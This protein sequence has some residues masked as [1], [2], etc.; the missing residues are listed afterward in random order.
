MTTMGAADAGGM[1]FVIREAAAEG[2]AQGGGGET[3]ADR[4]KKRKEKRRK[5]TTRGWKG[6]DKEDETAR[7][8]D[9]PSADGGEDDGAGGGAT[10]RKVKGLVCC[11]SL[12]RKYTYLNLSILVCRAHSQCWPR[13]R[14][15]WRNYNLGHGHIEELGAEDQAKVYK[16][17]L[18]RQ[19]LGLLD[20]HKN[21]IDLAVVL[22]SL[23]RKLGNLCVDGQGQGGD[24]AVR[25]GENSHI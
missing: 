7:R 23:E 9:T 10:S 13:C 18:H 16:N 22:Q 20:G 1:G 4:G 2:E 25:G 12:S 6:V 8:L 5:E 11:L 19:D 15:G 21:M 24:G 17:V 14:R 3:G